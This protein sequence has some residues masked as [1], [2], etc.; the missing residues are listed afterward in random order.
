MT[1]WPRRPF[2]LV[3]W[4]QDPDLTKLSGRP[5][6]SPP[7][8]GRVGRPA[9]SA[10]PGK[11]AKQ[12]EPEKDG[13]VGEQ[14][15]IPRSKFGNLKSAGRISNF[16]F[17]NSHWPTILFLL[18]LTAAIHGWLIGHT[19]LLARD[20]VGFIRYA[21]RL[22]REPWS[23][24]LRTSHQHPGYPWAIAVASGPVG[25]LV[26][27]SPCDQMTLSAQLI[28][29]LAGCLLAVAMYYLGLELFNRRVGFWSAALFQ[30][31]PVVARVTSDALSE[32]T[33]LLTST[34]TLL[35]AVRSLRDYSVWRL[36][37]CGASGGCCYL[38]RPEGAL[39]V[40]ATLTV[41]LGMQ[42]L[43]RRR[44]PWSTVLPAMG[45]LVISAAAVAGPYVAVIGHFTNKPTGQ[46]VMEVAKLGVRNQESGV[47]SQES[48]IKGRIF[49]SP[50][51]YHL[52]PCLLAVWWHADGENNWFDRRIWVPW[53]VAKEVIRSSGYFA[54]LPAL[55][56]LGWFYR[57]C[58]RNP[59]AW[60]LAV[61]CLFQAVLLCRVGSV[62]GYVSERHVL[63]I[64]LCGLYWAVWAML[65]IPQRWGRA[66]YQMRVE[67]GGWRIETKGESSAVRPSSILHSPS[68]IVH[69]PISI[70][71]PRSSILSSLMM[72]L[73]MLACLPMSL[74]PLHANQVGHRE[75]GLWLASHSRPGDTIVDPFDWAYF[76]AGRVFAEGCN[77]LP[78]P[79]PIRYVVLEHS[80]KPHADLSMLP[81]AR[82]LAEG[83]QIVYDWQPNQHQLKH[84]AQEVQ[85]LA[86]PLNS[87]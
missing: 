20:G 59:A 60:I 31:L 39:T 32:T 63:I 5:I 75:A 87:Q 48:E 22:Q 18:L 24:V 76:Y 28:N 7:G 68:S 74:Q 69:L 11:L 78:Q 35:L 29:L 21:W 62:V 51:S 14:I 13:I 4:V 86:V 67:K 44:R 27:S 45:S 25:W 36:A 53:T 77:L 55:L 49:L 12:Q 52:T 43:A 81:K 3:L 56:G 66:R 16:D 84:K 54:W 57:R 82:Q 70:L 41:L 83:G 30:C 46:A 80:R 19:E 8:E 17:R 65:Q 58:R 73:L 26:H 2:Q 50:D 33:F 64:V 38:I 72:V 47:R 37:L 71:H 40:V 1:E 10:R 9:S 23:E 6:G 79:Q 15:Q 42:A 85:I 34:V 61:L